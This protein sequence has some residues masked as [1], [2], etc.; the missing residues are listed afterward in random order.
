[1]SPPRIPEFPHSPFNHST[2]RYVT[3][4][5]PGPSHSHRTGSLLDRSFGSDSFR[6]YAISEAPRIT[7]FHAST[8]PLERFR[9]ESVRQTAAPQPA[10]ASAAFQQSVKYGS[11]PS[12]SQAVKQ[13]KGIA[14][15]KSGDMMLGATQPDEGLAWLAKVRREGQELRRMKSH[16][17]SVTSME[18][19]VGRQLEVDSPAQQI[20]AHNVKTL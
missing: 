18:V 9:H 13:E 2:P 5:H 8:V 7:V 3:F 11:R 16:P 15:A 1:M 6:R 19:N 14:Q 4:T 20:Q 10:F 12:C 17:A